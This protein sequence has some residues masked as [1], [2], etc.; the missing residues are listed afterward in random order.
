MERTVNAL[1]VNGVSENTLTIV[2]SDNGPWLMHERYAGSAGPFNGGKFTLQEGGVRMFA[3][4]HW[5]ARI[6]H[7]GTVST[8]VHQNT[9]PLVH[10]HT[11]VHTCEQH[12]HTCVQVRT[13]AHNHPCGTS[14]ENYFTS[15]FSFLSFPP[16]NVFI[17]FTLSSPQ[18][19]GPLDCG[20][21]TNLY[22]SGRSTY[23]P[24]N[25]RHALGWS[26]H[27]WRRNQRKVFE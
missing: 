6:Q 17:C 8:E 9:L 7:N 16:H 2:T 1:R 11:H 23:S 22:G 27:V 18:I 25:C 24:P 5:P 19:L 13:R 20:F 26:G 21:V 14:R 3:V 10:S 12:I 4:A 15:I